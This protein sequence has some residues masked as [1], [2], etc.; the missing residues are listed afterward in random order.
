[1]FRKAGS[2]TV[3]IASYGYLLFHERLFKGKAWNGIVLDEAQAIKDVAAADKK[4]R[5]GVLLAGLT[6]LRRF[7]C[8]PSLVL[9]KNAIGSAKLAAL[10]ELMEELREGGHRALV[11]SQFTDYL[12]IVRE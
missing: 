10:A 3:V 6:R 12:A 1:M 4:N 9:G 8:N 2:R 5:M 7:C 11:F